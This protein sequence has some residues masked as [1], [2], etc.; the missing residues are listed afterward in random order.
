MSFIWRY[1]LIWQGC[2]NSREEAGRWG[3]CSPFPWLI[4]S[5]EDPLVCDKSF[6]FCLTNCSFPKNVLNA[7]QQGE[8][9]CAYV[10]FCYLYWT[11]LSA[12]LCECSAIN[13]PHLGCTC[14]YTSSRSKFPHS[15]VHRYRKLLSCIYTYSYKTCSFTKFEGVSDC[16]LCSPF[17]HLSH[18]THV[19]VS[20][21]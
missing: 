21:V 7:A 6:P 17:V 13:R 16:I 9:S 14:L 1:T 11:S 19:C 4:F 15:N 3:I 10:V 2:I 5:L 20:L 18:I 8:Y 12:I